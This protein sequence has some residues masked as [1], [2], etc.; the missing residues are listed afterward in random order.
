MCKSSP[1]V[2]RVLKLFPQAQTTEISLYFG[3]TSGFIVK[4]SPIFKKAVK[5][6]TVIICVIQMKRQVERFAGAIF[7]TF[8]AALPE[9]SQRKIKSE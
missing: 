8:A 9:Q 4:W 5:E 2:E 6:Q 3:C 7:G 1:V